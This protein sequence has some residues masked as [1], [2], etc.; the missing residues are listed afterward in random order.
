MSSHRRAPGENGPNISRRQFL[1]NVVAGLATTSWV[2]SQAGRL[3][4]QG[5]RL[6]SNRRPDPANFESGDFIWPKKPEAFVPYNSKVSGTYDKDRLQWEREK[7]AFMRR[8]RSDPRSPRELLRLARGLERMEFR[9]FLALYLAD[10]KPGIPGTYGGR[11]PIYVGHVG[12]LLVKAD[13]E[14]S[15]VEAVW[16]EGVRVVSYQSW[17]RERQDNIFWHGRMRDL[18]RSD[19]ASIAD[20]ALRYAG[21]PYDFWNFNLAD[22]SGFYCSKLVWL[23][24][25]RTLRIATDDNPDPRRGFWYSPKQL[26][27]SAHIYKL[28][29]PA[30]Y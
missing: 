18:R 27:N 6:E 9:E 15:V 7:L 17:L 16:G 19:R 4:A 2:F 1:S 12:I 21:K 13:D 5:G 8:V 24:V 3:F 30:S 23:A 14:P 11:S 20:E 26:M 29:N 10:E 25:Y 28:S 22:D